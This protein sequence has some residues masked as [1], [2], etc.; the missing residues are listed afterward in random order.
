ME[1]T[2][3]RRSDRQTDRPTIRQGLNVFVFALKHF[4]M[5][6]LQELAVQASRIKEDN[7]PSLAEDYSSDSGMRGDTIHITK[8]ESIKQRKRKEERLEYLEIQ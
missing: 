2:K 7:K 6:T 5:N 3:E 1:R 8:R 4:I